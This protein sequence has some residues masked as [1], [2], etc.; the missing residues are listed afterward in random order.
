MYLLVKV[1]LHSEFGK[2]FCILSSHDDTFRSWL[3]LEQSRFDIWLQR[4]W[5]G[6][7]GLL[8]RDR[9]L[10]AGGRRRH[11][12]PDGHQEGGQ[13]GHRVREQKK[14]HQGENLLLGRNVC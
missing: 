8:G 13:Q 9:G 6:Q 7:C 3:R 10:L 2:Y 11:L 1:N 12:R 4:Q 14:T 5:A